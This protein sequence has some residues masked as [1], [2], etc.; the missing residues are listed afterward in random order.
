[1]K[2]NKYFL[3]SILAFLV[4]SC[5]D[6]EQG[7]VQP[8]PGQ[9]VKFGATLEKNATRT[10]YGEEENGAFPIYWKNGDNVVVF[11]PDCASSGGVGSA[12]YKVNVGDNTEQDFANSLDKTSEIGVRWGTNETGRFYSVYPASSLYTKVSVD[13]KKLTLIM[14]AQQD[15][16]FERK[17]QGD[18]SYKIIAQ[19]DMRACFMYAYTPDVNSGETVNLKYKP[20]STAIRFTLQGPQTGNPVTIIYVRIKAPNQNINGTY[21]FADVT[22]TNSGI[23]EPENGLDYV[24]MNV[25]DEKGKYLTLSPGESVELNAFLMIGHEVTIDNTWYMEVGTSSGKSYKLNLTSAAEGKN[26]ILKPG[27]IHRL[28]TLPTLSSDDWEVGTWMRNLQRNVYLSEISIPG[29]WNSL[30]PEFQG[31]NPSITEQY[32]NGV[33]AFHLDTRWIAKDEGNFINHDYKITELGIADGGPT[34]TVNDG[35]CMSADNATSFTTALGEI[36]ENVKDDEYMVVMCTFAQ[37]STMTTDQNG[38]DWR[39]AIST[40]CKN[41]TSVIDARDLNSNSTVADVLGKVIVIVNTYKPEEVTGPCL[42]VNLPMALVTEDTQ[43]GDIFKPGFLK[44]DYFE[45]PLKYNNSTESGI[46]MYATYAQITTNGDNGSDGGDR[47]YIPTFSEREEKVQNIL[48]WSKENYSGTASMHNVWIYLGLGGYIP[49]TG[50]LFGS[51]DDCTPVSKALNPWIDNKIKGME[52]DFY[53]PVGLVFMNE[54]TNAEYIP[55][56]K[57]ILQMNNKYRKAYDPNRS[58]VNGDYI[59]GNANSVQSAAPGYSSGMKDNQ[60]DAIGWSRC[61]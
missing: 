8:T 32:N 31:N 49:G 18:G 55:M 1:M 46:N 30:N 22:D 3:I 28:G 34:Y 24:T 7:G 26:G 52:T 20:I 25:A 23:P 39:Q 14:P 59:N 33:R 19:P 11:S 56:V 12:T 16:S 53:Y 40:V 41:N 13:C 43:E 10:I 2:T 15:N 9:D 58:P 38:Q 29:S 48:D 57:R 47:G 36:T 6:D 44:R 61:R 45:Q 54:T 60:T 17:Q 51:D 21:A 5:Q 37:G 42:Y 27:R 50:G 4:C 35:K